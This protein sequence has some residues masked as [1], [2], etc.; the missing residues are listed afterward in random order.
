M[1][2]KVAFVL[3]SLAGGGAERVSLT[4]LAGLDRSRFSPHLVLLDGRGPLRQLVPDDVAV[5]VL[6]RPRL[7]QALPMLVATLRRLRPAVTFSS[8]GYVNLALAACRLLLP[9]RL[10]LREANLPSLSLPNGPCPRAMAAAYRL[11]YRRADLVIATSRRMADELEAMGTRRV[12]LLPNPVDEDTLRVGLSP[13]RVAGPGLRL[14]AAGRLVHQKGFDRLIPQL[15][16]LDAHLT[17]LGEGP[18][19]ERLC[20]LAAQHGVALDLPGFDPAAAAWFAGADRLLLPSR[21]EG[22]P[23]VA[24]EALAVGCPVIATP[25]AGGIAEIAAAV[26]ADAVQLVDGT[27]GFAR[28]LDGV[29]PALPPG[30]R[31]SL[32]PDAWRRERVLERFQQMIAGCPLGG[33]R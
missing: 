27:V 18:E 10:I 19:R 2:A 24:L 4:L 17:I 1:A 26:A 23:N 6:E 22:M 14:V 12:A 29:V 30:L 5:T 21:W 9:G 32:L 3:P 28:A 16:G 15:V 33:R 25:E 11:L 20:A 13:R 8:L 31:P 7:R